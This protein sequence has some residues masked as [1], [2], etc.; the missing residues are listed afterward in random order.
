MLDTAP[1]DTSGCTTE[2]ALS[3]GSFGSDFNGGKL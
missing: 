3:A 1:H 2:V